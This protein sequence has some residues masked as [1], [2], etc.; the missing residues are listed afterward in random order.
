MAGVPIIATP[1][2]DGSFQHIVHQNVSM[3]SAAVSEKRIVKKLF[4]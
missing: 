1:R 4:E 2:I 3:T